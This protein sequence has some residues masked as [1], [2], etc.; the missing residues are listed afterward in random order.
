M[1][2][3]KEISGNISTGETFSV[4]SLLGVVFIIL[5]LCHVISWSWIWV[6]AP[7]WI[8]VTIYLG[9]FTIVFLIVVMAAIVASII[10]WSE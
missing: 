10:D 1:K 9:I 8:P 5:K 7:F 2:K 4:T 3:V 6:L